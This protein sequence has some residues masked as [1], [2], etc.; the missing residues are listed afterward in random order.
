MIITIL[1][2][3]GVGKS[4]IAQQLA[5]TLGYEFIDL[6]AYIELKENMSVNDIFKTKGEL[7]FRKQEHLH[8]KS[9]LS[10]KTNIVLA[11]GGGTPCYAGNMQLIKDSGANTVYLKMSPK[12]LS[13]RLFVE[14]DS[15]PL[16][17]HLKTEDS[18]LEFIAIHIFERQVYYQKAKH[19][20]TTDALTATEVVSK[21]C[22]G[23]A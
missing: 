17:S 8:L 14:K 18:L 21:I 19:V 20:I 10:L 4:T 13:K 22:E 16:I 2:Y 6:D 23:L 5:T 7:F 1:G 12:L 3:M 9:I 15:R 11:L